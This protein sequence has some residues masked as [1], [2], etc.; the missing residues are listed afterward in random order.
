M[1][2]V[3][4]DNFSI[5]GTNRNLLLD[6]IYVQSSNSTHLVADPDGMSPGYVL[7]CRVST[8]SDLVRLRYVLPHADT[9]VGCSQRIW[10]EELPSSSDM[11]PVPIQFA[12]ISNSLIGYL[13]VDPS[14][15]LGFVNN[16]EGVTSWSDGPVVTANGW[17]HIETRLKIDPSEGGFEVR[18][19]GRTVINVENVST[20]T[21]PIGQVRIANYPTAISLGVIYYVKDFVIWDGSG[22]RNNDFLGTV[23][24]QNL[25]PSADVQL[26]WTP[27]TGDNG[28]SILSSIPPNDSNYISAEDDPLPGP[29][30][31]ELTS[32][33][34]DV[35]SVRGLITFVRAAK[36]DGG[37]GSIQ[38]G[39]IS[40][41]DD[42]PATVLGENRPITVAQTYWRDVFEVDPKTGS[43]WTPEA[44][45]NVHLQITRTT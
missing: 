4:A 2:I 40:S 10:L 6:G 38:V 5:Y 7:Q 18:V 21:S 29:Y 27:S 32:L 22:D 9:V 30:V 34:E 39:L 15:R 25:K 14:G 3:H 31:A 8:P 43:G 24:V 35:T 16:I 12:T 41:P 1:A 42:D 33:P 11:T 26:N 13:R 28:Y 37:D 17:Y 23:L 45:N 19:E 20:G 44:V 36:S